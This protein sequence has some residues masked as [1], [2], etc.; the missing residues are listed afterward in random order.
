[1]AG[2]DGLDRGRLL[3][4]ND[5]ISAIERSFLLSDGL[6]G[7]PWFKHAIYAP[8]LTTG[9]ASWPLPAVRQAI[10]ENKPAPL[11]TAVAKTSGRIRQAAG[12]LRAAAE[13]ARSASEAG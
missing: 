3:S 13:R 9:Y 7:R 1:A 2:R 11:A 10:E 5:A 8:G 12:A 4:L 6:P